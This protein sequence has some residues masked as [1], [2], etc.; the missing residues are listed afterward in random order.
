MKKF[1]HIMMF[2]AVAAAALVS[3][4]KETEAPEK[5]KDEGIRITVVA[6]DAVTKTTLSGTNKTAW[7]NGVDKVG[8]INGT[9]GVNVE[10]SAASVNAS[11]Q[12][13]FTGTVP[14]AGTYYA[15]YPYFNDASYG[16]TADGV[17]VRIPNEQAA[18]ANNFAPAADVLV[19]EAFTVDAAG[20]Y[21]TQPTVL[22][23][24]RLTAFL[25][26]T[27]TDATTGNK[28]SGQKV[29]SVA[30]QGANNLVGRYR[31]HGVNGLVDQG[32]GYKKVTATYA[33]DFN[34]T[35]DAAYL[36][37]APQ[38]LANGSALTITVETG[39]YTI[40]KTVTLTSDVVIGAG[41]VLPINFK[42]TDAEA[43][44]KTVSVSR[45]W[46]L[47]SNST[48]AWNNYYGGTANTDRNVA[49]DSDYIY[50]CETVQ[51]T[52]KV[53]AIS[54]TDN[55]SVT[56]VSVEGIKTT[57][58]WPTACPRVIKNT[59]ASINGGKD[60]LVV[61]SMSNAQDAL[62]IYAYLDGITNKPTPVQLGGLITGRRLGDTFTHWGT[63]QKGMFFFKDFGAKNMMS[64]KL[65]GFDW[66]AAKTAYNTDGT[67][68]KI[69]AQGNIV[70]P[71]TGAGG[72]FPYPNDKN[73]GFFGIR[74]DVQ[75]YTFKMPTDVWSASGLIEDAVS[76]S[77]GSGYFTNATC[78]L[79]FE[80]GAYKYVV[81][82]R[83][84]SGKAGGVMF[85]RGAYTSS[86][87][88]IINARISGGS[89]VAVFSIAANSTDATEEN[90]LSSGHAGFDLAAYKIGDD[91]YVAA[92][93]QNVGLSLFK[94]SAE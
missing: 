9:A 33:A 73:N 30:V 10:S 53:W 66:A 42:V 5:I 74:S 18:V 56:A 81:Y 57:S 75:A 21:S 40:T 71:T 80:V 77:T 88:D 35:S 2:A 94:V 79:Y 7:V 11:G 54:R 39:S 69:A 51:N 26:V 32:S 68:Q 38:T 60:V 14:A 65:S 48:N 3:C 28:L 29:T 83:Q 61:A 44:S 49:M 84:V 50:I 92:V 46:G 23:F 45:V 90:A 62:Y 82:T 43:L 85:L 6:G 64:Y 1:T 19:S 12:A 63:L 72:Y 41:D 17:T 52:P 34:A 37:I 55:T 78:A 24:R 89:T 87:A 67:I 22:R 20:S 86:Y 27:L 76:T 47:Y 8:F 25:K 36:G 15:Y 13:S 70:G 59:D 58:F 93:K 4:N 31:V 91:V 16:P